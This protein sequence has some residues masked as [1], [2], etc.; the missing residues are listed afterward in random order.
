MLLLSF[1]I[2]LPYIFN[3]FDVKCPKDISCICRV[4]CS[5]PKCNDQILAQRTDSKKY[6]FKKWG[7][8]IEG[9]ATIVGAVMQFDSYQWFPA[10]P[11]FPT[12]VLRQLGLMFTFG[13]SSLATVMVLPLLRS[14]CHKYKCVEEQIQWKSY[15]LQHYRHLN[16]VLV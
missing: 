3:N 6:L 15:L 14:Y 2:Q 12:G 7:F 11:P 9:T 8:V 5:P 16:Y 1:S 13:Y 4:N 10:F